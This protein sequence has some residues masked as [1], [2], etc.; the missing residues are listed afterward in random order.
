MSPN[1]HS[2]SP[3]R[4]WR[5]IAPELAAERD[6]IRASALAREMEQSILEELVGE[7]DPVRASVLAREMEHLMLEEENR[8]V[9][10]LL[11][12]RPPDALTS[13]A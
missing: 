8:R 10:R 9:S 2:L 6:P 12:R 5:V 4:D 13:A 3:K 11:T 1:Q 7:T